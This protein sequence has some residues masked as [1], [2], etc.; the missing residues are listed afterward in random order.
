MDL[1]ITYLDHSGFAVSQNDNVY[2]F[3]YSNTTPA[4]GKNGFSGG[5]VDPAQLS[6][7]QVFVFVSHRHGDHFLP[8]IYKWRE[9]L[10]DINYIIS[11]DVHP[12]AFAHSVKP[13]EHYSIAGINILTLKSTDEGVAFLIEA[14]GKTIYHAGDLNWWHWDGEPKAWNNNMA[15]NYKAQIDMLKGKHIGLAFV[16]VDPRL[17]NELL[18]GLDYLMKTADVTKAI[19]MHFWNQP[20]RVEQAF[21]CPDAAA[22]RERLLPPMAR[23]AQIRL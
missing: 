16:P 11:K 7:K 10:P 9:Q 20:E 12:P 4:S 13:N 6:G 17:G 23:G 22:Y 3:D 5:I 18:W 14:D 1:T 15:A 19:P 2:I 8:E 21:A